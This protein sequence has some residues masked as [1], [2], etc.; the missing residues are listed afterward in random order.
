[1]SG[2]T[3]LSN[4]TTIYGTSNISGM[5]RLANNTT[6][7]SSLNVSGNSNFNN[8]NVSGSTYFYGHLFAQ[9]NIYGRSL[10]PAFDPANPNL[11]LSLSTRGTGILNFNVS[12][13]SRM[14]INNNNTS[15]NTSLNV[16][17]RTI[18][19]TDIYNYSDSVLE[20][21]RNF[22]IRKNPDNGE[23]VQMRVGSTLSSYL[24]IQEGANITLGTPNYATSN[25]II[26]LKSQKQIKLDSPDVYITGVA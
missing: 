9:Q 16:S 20:A 13:M 5:S 1:M 22:N 24:T 14:I 26:E 15:I 8:V 23:I 7:L 18:F 21:Y 19:G 25:S 6:L 17:G 10:L 3:L 2:I 4:N 11:S 12:G